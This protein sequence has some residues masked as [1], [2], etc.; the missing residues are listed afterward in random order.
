M[1]LNEFKIL[2]LKLKKFNIFSLKNTNVHSTL[3]LGLLILLKNN[4]FS[5]IKYLQCMLWEQSYQRWGCQ[6]HK[7]LVLTARRRAS[8]T[9]AF[10]PPATAI[11]PLPFVTS[12]LCKYFPN[13][14]HNIGHASHIILGNHFQFKLLT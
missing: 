8:I 12:P 4:N 11:I 7:F 5:L 10:P 1:F 6:C 2:I 13:L 3:A 9:T 14:I